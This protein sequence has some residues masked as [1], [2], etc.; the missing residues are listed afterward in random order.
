MFARVQ[1]V[2]QPA[3][4]LDA[5]AEIAARQLP[6]AHDLA[7]FKGLYY[8]VDRDNGKALVIS[9]W[10][11]EEHLRQLEAHAKVR[12]EVEAKAGIK[13]PPSEI[14]RVAVTAG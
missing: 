4:K 7:G 5:L 11:R 13:S 10:E 3:E 14:F 8:L 9:L 2:H 12:D 1:T 6:D